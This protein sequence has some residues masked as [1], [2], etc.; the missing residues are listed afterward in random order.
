[1]TNATHLNLINK[2][3][4]KTGASVAM[5]RNVDAAPIA[6]GEIIRRAA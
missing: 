6:W 2:V 1:M 3:N 5:W 4:K